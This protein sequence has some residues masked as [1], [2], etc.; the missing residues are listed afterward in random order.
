MNV[1][2]GFRMGKVYFSKTHRPVRNEE[3]NNDDLDPNR[4]VA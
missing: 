3:S 4:F 1:L 2:C